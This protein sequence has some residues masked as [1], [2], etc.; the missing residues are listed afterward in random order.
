MGR[1]TFQL[2]S[3]STPQPLTCETVEGGYRLTWED[4]EGQRHEECLQIESPE[5]GQ[6]WLNQGGRI[7]PF[8]YHHTPEALHLWVAGATYVLPLLSQGP[9]RGGAEGGALPA[10]GEIKAP[11][12]G[13]ILQLKVSQGDTV[14]ANQPLI[15]MESMKMEMTLAAPHEGWVAG[16]HCQEGQLVEM[17]T[18]LVTLES[19][20]EKDAEVSPS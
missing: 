13:T 17:G 16:L 1:V 8:Y 9:R 12:P 7:V 6:G 10:S 4:A 2:P 14:S 5:P 19:L 3:T 20:V 15:I 11:M 18:I